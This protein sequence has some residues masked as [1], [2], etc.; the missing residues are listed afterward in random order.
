MR[1]LCGSRG[2]LQVFACSGGEHGKPVGLGP[3]GSSPL[4]THP[5]EDPSSS[6]PP[7]LL[8]IICVSSFTHKE[9]KL[10]C[11]GH[12]TEHEIEP[13]WKKSHD[14]FSS[15]L[16]DSLGSF[17]TWDVLF[18]IICTCFFLIYEIDRVHLIFFLRT[19]LC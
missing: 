9:N 19:F 3:G 15:F 6:S 10:S 18:G 5:L 13:V 14:C 12:K 8:S 16:S 11:S 17:S 1:L 2:R 7:L 4:Q